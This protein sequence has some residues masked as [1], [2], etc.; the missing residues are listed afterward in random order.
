MVVFAIEDMNTLRLSTEEKILSVVR[1]LNLLVTIID[2]VFIMWILDALNNTM[3][4]LENMNQSRK[5][6]RFLKLRCLF[7]F[8]ILFA[9]MWTVFTIVHTVDEEGIVGEE[10]AWAIDAATEVNY[11]FVLI[12]VA[13]LWRPNPSAREYAYVMELPGMGTY[14]DNEFELAGVVPSAA[15]DDDDGS[16]GKN[17]F[18]EK[19]FHDE[20][21][22]GENDHRF[23]IT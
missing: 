4:Y 20:E 8:A 16:A 15:D 3:L 7:L 1:M 5:L 13:Y 6:E 2:V 14:E 18:H 17:G 9:V 22:D 12:G 19:G 23:Q 10:W 11:L 21:P